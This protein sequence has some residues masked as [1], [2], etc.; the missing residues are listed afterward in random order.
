MYLIK[1]IRRRIFYYSIDAYFAFLTYSKSLDDADIQLPF[2]FSIQAVDMGKPDERQ[3]LMNLWI[4]AY[5]DSQKQDIDKADNEIS[6]LV[7]NDNICLGLFFRTKLIG[8]Q[9]IGFDRAI[10]TMEFT[11]I[12]KNHSSA[13][14]Q[15]HGFISIEY[16]GQQLYVPLTK[17]CQITAKRLGREQIY[18]F[19]GVLNFAATK[20]LMRSSDAFNL[21]Y[22]LKIEIPFFTFNF[23][24]GSDISKW[25]TCREK[26]IL[27]HSLDT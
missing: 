3:A 15:H 8:M 2:G 25:R 18:G 19:V 14:V 17:A 4:T 16:R 22:H 23:F 27:D 11:K 26:P 21:L 6:Q 7:Q 24:P 13:A 10:D 1:N 9:W 20:I 12:L 5:Y